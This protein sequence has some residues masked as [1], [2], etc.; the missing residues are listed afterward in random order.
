MHNKI[1]KNEV[2]KQ[3]F[4]SHSKSIESLH[5]KM[6]ILETQLKETQKIANESRNENMKKLDQL[7]DS[8]NGCQSEVARC[9]SKTEIYSMNVSKCYQDLIDFK[10]HITDLLLSFKIEIMVQ[11]ETTLKELLVIQNTKETVNLDINKTKESLFA[12]DLKLE[13]YRVTL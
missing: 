9:L 1:D 6:Y 2:V 13:E 12:F 4:A 10:E 7:L 8:V 11:Y 5:N 3:K